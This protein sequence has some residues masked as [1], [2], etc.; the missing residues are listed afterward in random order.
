[1]RRRHEISK[2]PNRQ[3]S[4]SGFTLVELLVVITIIGI[5]IALLLP[6]VQAAR[7][8]A[9]KMQCSNNLKQMGTALHNFAAAYGCLPPGVM[10]ETTAACNSLDGTPNEPK[11]FYRF[12]VFVRI[13]PYLEL[14][15]VYDQFD[16]QINGWLPPNLAPFP[17][18]ACRSLATYALPTGPRFGRSISGSMAWATRRWGITP[19]RSA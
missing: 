14:N 15:N 4:K 19:T 3:I 8:A 5:L 7:E 12:T 11:P 16:P 2:P 1:M 10:M 18:A 17:L 6:A 9:R 13:L